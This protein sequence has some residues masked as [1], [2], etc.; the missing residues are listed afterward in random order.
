MNGKSLLLSTATLLVA[1]SCLTAANAVEGFFSRFNPF[2][3]RKAATT[4][5][6]TSPTAPP[7]AASQ[8]Q[9][10]TTDQLRSQMAS[11]GFDQAAID[12]RI[13]QMEQRRDSGEA[14]AAG[15]TRPSIDD[16]RTRMTENGVDPS[17]IDSRIDTMTQRQAYR[18]SPQTGSDG[19]DRS[20]FDRSKM[21]DFGG[22]QS[23]RPEGVG[24]RGSFGGGMRR[25]SR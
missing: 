13:E 6:T 18:S 23:T 10:P 24:S 9:R 1:S 12:S 3:S 11:Q 21:Q 5:T 16:V 15:Q 7:V 19:L 17:T 20:G 25:G 2:R 22:M 14:R 4:Q 8:Y